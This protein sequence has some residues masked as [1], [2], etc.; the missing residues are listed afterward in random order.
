MMVAWQ[1]LCTRDN[2]AVYSTCQASEAYPQKLQEARAR[3]LLRIAWGV[4]HIR[5]F[6][7]VWTSAV[8]HSVAATVITA[9]SIVG[10]RK[11]YPCTLKIV[12]E[13]IR[14]PRQPIAHRSQ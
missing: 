3:Q 8:H 14:K 12:V 1:I 6:C 4:P 9:N 13:H 5:A 10:R 7:D 11:K 2:S